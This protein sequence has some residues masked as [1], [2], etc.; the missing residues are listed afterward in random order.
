LVIEVTDNSFI[1]DSQNL[2][3]Q[4]LIP[5]VHQGLVFEIK[6]TQF[7]QVIGKRLAFR[8][9]LLKTAKAAVHRVPSGVDNFSVWQDRFDKP[10]V[11]EVIGHFVREKGRCA[12][13]LTRLAYV[14]LAQGFQ[15][16]AAHRGH[17]LRENAALSRSTDPLCNQRD[18]V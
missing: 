11:C 18:I 12:A 10:H 5:M 6:L 9:V 1:L 14:S 15:F 13:V 16:S 3:W 4:Y 7:E 17:G 2:P 8:E